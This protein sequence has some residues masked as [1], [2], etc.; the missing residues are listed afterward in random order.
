METQK[1]I[2]MVSFLL[3]VVGGLNWGL[4]G[5]FDINLVE[6]IFGSSPQ[7]EQLVYILVGVAS[8]YVFVTHQANCKVCKK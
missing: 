3:L 5:M 6:M 1:M 4:I 8:I 2:H 7:L